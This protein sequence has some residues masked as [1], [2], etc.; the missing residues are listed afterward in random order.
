MKKIW[1]V[2]LNWNWYS[3]TV[4]CINSL[5][6]NSY[7]EITIILLDNA[8]KNGEWNNLKEL[9]WDKIIFIQNK[10]NLWFAW[11]CNIWIKKA[12]DIWC[13]YVM[14]F[15]NDA[16]AKDWFIERLLA[17]S[18]VD[19]EIGIVWP[20]I[21]YHNSEKIW[22]WWGVIWIYS[23][24]NR[25]LSKW[26]NYS[27]SKHKKPSAV[28]YITWCCMLTKKDVFESIWLLDE[29]Y[30]AYYEEADFCYKAKWGGYKIVVVPDALIEHKKSASSGVK[31][32]NQL[33]KIQAYL[34]ARNW[35]MFAKK[36]L[37]GFQRFT[38]LCSQYTIK[39]SF[40][41]LWNIKSYDVFKEYIRWLLSR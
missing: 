1:I 20:F 28:D 31:W 26:S 6:D 37:K 41:L 25:H 36:N 16:I 14:L 34:I 17:V 35:I 7:K 19:S 11:W 32:K 22:F 40:N 30:F 23:G 9:F 10:E 8:S 24:I 15:N 3:D 33:S 39:L 4:E 21:N 18:E 2:V 13:D 5:L 38:N 29:E 27:N 12:L